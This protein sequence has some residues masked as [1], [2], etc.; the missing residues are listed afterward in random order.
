MENITKVPEVSSASKKSIEDA[1]E[2][3]L[4]KVAKKCQEYQGCL[5]K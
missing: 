5:G 1:V 2:D 4:K 3:G